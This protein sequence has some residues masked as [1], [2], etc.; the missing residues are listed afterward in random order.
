MK[1]TILKKIFIKKEAGFTIIESLVAIFILILSI[2]GPMAFTQSGLR[3]AFVSRDQI[4]AFFLAQD[5]IEYIRNT[6]DNTSID[7]LGGTNKS[8]LIDLNNCIVN[9]ISA[10]GCTIDTSDTNPANIKKCNAGPTDYGCLGSNPDG[11]G[12]VPLKIRSNDPNDD[13]YGFLGFQGEKDSI[14]SREIKMI[15]GGFDDEYE[16]NVIVRWNTHETI[17]VRQIVIKEYIYN[18]ATGF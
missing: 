6:R 2:T 9:D 13:L 16:I 5:A 15:K 12:D 17:G 14:F 3:A 4:G 7:I 10:P 11:S 8:W 18:W 1:K